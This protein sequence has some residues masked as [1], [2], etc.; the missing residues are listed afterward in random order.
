M[1]ENIPQELSFEAALNELEMLV[2]KM[3]NGRLS[4]DELISGFERGQKLAGLCRSKLDNLE[5]KISLLAKDDGNNG[6]WQDFETAESSES[7]SPRANASVQ[8]QD[9]PF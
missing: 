6:I 1:S 3:E 7:I 2:G 8:N 4:L 9:I 5:R